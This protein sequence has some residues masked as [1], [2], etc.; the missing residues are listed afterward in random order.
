M[1]G[2]KMGLNYDQEFD[3]IFVKLR[4]TKYKC[5]EQLS[6]D[7]DVLYDVDDQILGIE[8]LYASNGISLSDLPATDIPELHR[9]IVA[10][11]FII[12]D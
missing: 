5:S 10:G 12:K 6:Y 11:G 9:L 8:F 2:F 4:N 7:R 3:I 1:P